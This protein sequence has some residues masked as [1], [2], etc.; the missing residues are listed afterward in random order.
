[1]R[2]A[3][4][5]QAK[6]ES[7]VPMHQ[8]HMSFI[9]IKL[10]IRFTLYK[11][12]NIIL[13]AAPWRCRRRSSRRCRWTTW[14][15]WRWPPRRR[16]APGTAAARIRTVSNNTIILS[17]LLSLNVQTWPPRRRPAPGAAELSVVLSITLYHIISRHV[18]YHVTWDVIHHVTTRHIIPH[19][20][21]SIQHIA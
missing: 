20:I 18:T 10:K 2:R 4:A 13:C 16:P 5:V 12:Y 8:Y 3:L 6:V 9:N 21:P 17:V 19:R 7:T 15:R 1:M 11:Y 14:W